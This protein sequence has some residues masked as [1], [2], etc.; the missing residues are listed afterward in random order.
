MDKLVIEGGVALKGEVRI[1][2]AKN[3]ALH[4][5]AILAL[6]DPALARRLEAWR[7]AQTRSVAEMPS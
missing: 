6:S 3:A 1:S 4:A 7:E 5:A 2:G